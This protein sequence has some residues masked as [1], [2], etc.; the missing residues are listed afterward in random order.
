MDDICPINKLKNNNSVC[1]RCEPEGVWSDESK[2]CVSI[3]LHESIGG[4]CSQN[5]YLKRDAPFKPTIDC[6]DP[7]SCGEGCTYTPPSEG[8]SESCIANP[9]Y[10]DRSNNDITL[11]NI[12]SNEMGF[13]YECS[14]CS[15]YDER[16]EEIPT[17]DTPTQ[18]GCGKKS[19]PTDSTLYR[20]NRYEY[21]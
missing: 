5:K 9:I 17:S 1:E 4:G 19:M 15:N 3:G 12:E 13:Q 2:S 6:G 8:V 11:T 18:K 20:Y 21:N 10:Q 14:S 7:G 16:C